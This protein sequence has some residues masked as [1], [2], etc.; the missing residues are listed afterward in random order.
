MAKLL[1]VAYITKS[2]SESGPGEEQILN[3]LQ[4]LD[5]KFEDVAGWDVNSSQGI[6]VAHE[7]YIAAVFRGTDEAKDWLDNAKHYLI[8]TEAQLVLGAGRA[9]AG[10]A[11]RRRPI[12]APSPRG[13]SAG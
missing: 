5:A 8:T 6:V 1:Q 3:Q 11:V 7:N 9:S 13:G 2:E 10:S 4:A 12:V